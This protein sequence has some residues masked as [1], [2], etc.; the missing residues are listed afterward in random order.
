MQ[1][2]DCLLGEEHDS[3]CALGQWPWHYVC[4]HVLHERVFL[5]WLQKG[6]TLLTQPL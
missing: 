6:S 2:G 1:L 4:G 5:S 3:F